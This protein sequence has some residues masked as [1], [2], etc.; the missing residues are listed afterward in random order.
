MSQ[1]Y[2]KIHGCNPSPELGPREEAGE[3]T[4]QEKQKEEFVAFCRV[5]SGRIEPGKQVGA[6]RC[7]VIFT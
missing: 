1:N 5:Y 7:D 4:P 3:E 6:D 2:Y